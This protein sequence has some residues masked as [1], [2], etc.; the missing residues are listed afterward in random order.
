MCILCFK[1][2]NAKIASAIKEQFYR[3]GIQIS[4]KSRQLNAFAE[5]LCDAT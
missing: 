4:Y 5:Q 2:R 3:Y 1:T